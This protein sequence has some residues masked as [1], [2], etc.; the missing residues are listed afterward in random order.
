MINLRRVYR[1]AEE[2]TAAFAAG[3]FGLLVF[4]IALQTIFSPS[5]VLAGVIVCSILVLTAVRPHWTLGVLAIYLPFESLVLKFTPDEVYVFARYFP[6]TLIYVVAAVVLWGIFSG[7]KP[8]RSTRFDLPMALLLL[9]LGASALVNL[10]DPTIAILGLRQILRFILVFFLVVQM[11]PSKKFVMNLTW[12]MLGI[13]IFQSGLGILQSLVGERL[14]A[15]LLP[16]DVRTLGAITLTEGVQQFWDPGSRV[17]ATLGRYDRL[18][19][20][21]YI[22]LLI[23][24]G[25]IFTEK[26]YKKYPWLVWLF[27]AAVPTLILTYSRS[28]WFAFLLGFLFIG[29]MMKKDP[30]V[31]AGLTAFVVFLVLALGAS[32]LNVSLIT[33]T[34]GQSLSERF[35]ESFSYA[36]WRGE[37]Y[38]LGRVFWYVHTPK[39]VVAASPVLGFGP[40]QFGGGAVSALHNTSVYEALGLPYG[41]FGTEGF[42]DNN[43]FSL[44]GEG[45]TLGLGLYLWLYLA[46]FLYAIRVARTHHDAYTRALALGVC[47]MLIGVAF[48]AFTSTIFEIRTSGYYLWL[49]AGLLY[50]LASRGKQGIV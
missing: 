27:V 21:L 22:F 35:Y 7:K 46:I 6:E 36:R 4:L 26:V 11:A 47:A 19:N 45:G 41:V 43:W 34:P 13:V 15:F 1:R 49:Y 5:L 32:G 10:V 24:T 29:L 42:I 40:G 28:S 38:G 14:D 18:G 23:A 3:L 30:R 31:L 20:F 39:D 50:A 25:M 2:H 8:W 37:Y 12:V 16:S 44:W 48:N 33:E 17:F 9:S